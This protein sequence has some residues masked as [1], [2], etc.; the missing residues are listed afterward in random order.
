MMYLR[1]WQKLN[2]MGFS[3]TGKGDSDLP[4]N[5]KDKI[6]T[7]KD[8][9]KGDLFCHLTY[10]SAIATSHIQRTLL[11]EYAANLPYY[12]SRYFR[13]VHYMAKKLNY[14][15]TEACRIVGESTKEAEPKAILLRM[16]GALASGEN[17]SDFLA[18][19]A[20]AIGE[21]YGDDYERS[22]ESLRKWTDAYV[23][24]ILSTSLVVVVS[25]VSMLIF[26]ISPMYITMLT[27][28]MLVATV[29]GAW[30]MFRSSPKEVKTHTLAQTSSDRKLAK[31]LFKLTIIPAGLALVLLMFVLKANLG[32][33]MVIMGLLAMPTGL[34]IMRDDKR[35]DRQDSDIAGFLRSLGGITKAIGT[36]AN[37]ALGR[38][39]FGSLASLKKPV[40]SL[41]NS[42]AL[43][44]KP[45]LCWRRFV[46][47]TGSEHINRSV[48]IFW[49][50]ISIGGDPDKVGNQASMFALKVS[51]L[52]AK[53]KL[54]SSTFSYTCLL[55]HGT[56]A[57]L[58]V[59]IYQVLVNFSGLLSSMGS[60]SS[61][62]TQ[63]ISQLPTFQFFSNSSAQLQILNFM[64]TAMLVVL[65]LTNA[66][67]IKVVE[68]G[69][70]LKLVFY[71]GLTLIISGISLLLVPDLLKGVF[72][73]L[74]MPK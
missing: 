1:F 52:R 49:D 45:D 74:A 27:F 35:I 21:M 33:T 46:G 29:M 63:A 7:N 8:L 14:D 30:I 56:I 41:Y 60:L 34:I 66:V 38:L 19:E 67:A 28:L 51:L 4:S 36:T 70:N 71:V 16:A 39:D 43:G 26:P 22:V 72:G 53:R 40:K 58:L 11:F 20:Y 48:R 32:L 10:M 73:S 15:Y 47:N 25:V 31:K 17:E 62:T 6:S 57:L 2:V 54:I 69:H 37:E 13:K 23:A 68:G 64:V 24:I 55:I 42:I 3:K 65:T 9:L 50:G 18:R 5:G 59:G 61:D 12:S 44:I